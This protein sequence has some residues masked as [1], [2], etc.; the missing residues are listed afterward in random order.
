MRRKIDPALYNEQRLREKP[1]PKS[2]PSA[3][4]N[5]RP[6]IRPTQSKPPNTV[7]V[8]RDVQIDTPPSSPISTAEQVPS[9]T[10]SENVDLPVSQSSTEDVICLTEATNAA[11]H[12]PFSAFDVISGRHSF[13]CTVTN[14]SFIGNL[15]ETK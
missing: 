12:R 11:R 1:Y 9:D 14:H 13:T 2:K 6:I 4:P 8:I 7:V 3:Q 15:N 5:S 10:D